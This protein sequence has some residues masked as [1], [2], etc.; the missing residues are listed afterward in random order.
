MKGIIEEK[1]IE[2]PLWTET[3]YWL[4]GQ[5]LNAKPNSWGVI[6]E[7][8]EHLYYLS[9]TEK[10]DLLLNKGFVGHY[11]DDL[12][13]TEI[14][15]KVF[16][17]LIEEKDSNGNSVNKRIKKSELKNRKIISEINPHTNK[18]YHPHQFAGISPWK[19]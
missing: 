2:Y 1:I 17:I 11:A 3:E 4:N 16:E 15:D 14:Q 13:N 6:N 18:F 7:N 5:K 19:E 9:S 10:E 12:I 8:K